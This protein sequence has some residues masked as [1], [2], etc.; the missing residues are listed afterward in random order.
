MTSR[1]LRPLR[2]NSARRTSSTASLACWM[3][4]NLSYTIRHAGAHSSILS[5]NGT[6]MSTQAASMRLRWPLLSCVRKYSSSVSF[7]RSFPNHSGSPVSRLTYHR[8]KLV[9]FPPV[10]LVHPHLFQ[11]GLATPLVPPLQVAHVDRAHCRLWQVE[12][13]RHLAGG[14][15]LAGFPHD[16]FESLAERRLAR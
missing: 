11:R 8:Q 12:T 6:H 9:V 5:R 4:W 10:D 14:G 2:K 1:I 15:T 7:F 13:P 3:M 16:L